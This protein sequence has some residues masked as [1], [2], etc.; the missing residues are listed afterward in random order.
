MKKY[1]AALITTLLCA[2]CLRAGDSP[3]KL[4]GI[5][6]GTYDQT[7]VSTDWSGT[8]KNSYDWH[9]KLDATAD[10][11]GPETEWVSTLKE[12]IGKSKVDDSAELKN[13][14]VIDFTS[15]YSYKLSL[16]VNPYAAMTFTTQNQVFL[17]PAAYV[18]SGGV[19][20]QLVK[21]DRQNLKTRFGIAF[22]QN[23]FTN[24]VAVPPVKVATQNTGMEWV[25]NYDLLIM[26]DTRFISEART[27]NAF[28]GGINLRWDNALYLKMTKYLTTQF[29][30]LVVYNYDKIP[31]PTWAD[32]IETRFTVTFGISYNIF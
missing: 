14:D 9:A 6:G 5:A 18:E 17:D 24:Y 27:F 22:R 29:E 19:S 21:N 10:R 2:P 28:K 13:A 7:V 23:Y 12:E 25:T 26:K 3:W 8:E 16:L 32:G 20:L 15:V 4:Q 1:F 11:D 31:A 30:Y